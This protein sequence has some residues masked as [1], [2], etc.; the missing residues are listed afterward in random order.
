MFMFSCLILHIANI[1]APVLCNGTTFVPH[2]IRSCVYF[3]F[4]ALSCQVFLGSVL[5][6]VHYLDHFQ[7]YLYIALMFL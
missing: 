7:E 1:M 3:V 4:I 2:V 5:S 6:L